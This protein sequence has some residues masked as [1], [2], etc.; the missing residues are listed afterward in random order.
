MIPLPEDLLRPVMCSRIL[1][2]ALLA[3]AFAAVPLAQQARQPFSR[4]AVRVTPDRA[5]WTYKPGEP[6]TFRISV[7]R[8][9]HQVAGTAVKYAI[10]P[11]M[12][13]P[14]RESSAVV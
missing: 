13:P 12:M 11:E 6:V 8:D 10:G 2:A 4:V 1:P 14:T 5:D 3:V 9:G 7:T